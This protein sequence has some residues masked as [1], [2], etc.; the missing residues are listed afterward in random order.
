MNMTKTETYYLPNGRAVQ[1]HADVSR[2]APTVS[3]QLADGSSVEATKEP[4]NCAECGVDMTD[5]Y[6]RYPDGACRWCPRP[7]TFAGFLA[8]CVADCIESS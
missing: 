4:A 7:Q 1:I 6:N 3:F 2:A 5:G 8:A